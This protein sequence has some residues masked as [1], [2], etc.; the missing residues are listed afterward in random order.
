MQQLVTT[1]THCS[2][3]VASS[4]HAA[5]DGPALVHL[6]NDGSSPAMGC[7]TRHLM[8]G[9]QQWTVARLCEAALHCTA[10]NTEPL[11]TAQHIAVR[12]LVTRSWASLRPWATR[13]Q[14]H[15]ASTSQS[16][17]T[18]HLLPTAVLAHCQAH[19]QPGGSPLIKNKGHDWQTP[20][21]SLAHPHACSH[22][23]V[24]R[25]A[26]HSWYDVALP[27]PS[28]HGGSACRALASIQLQASRQTLPKQSSF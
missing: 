6:F 22:H 18:C 12:Q 8:V 10:A 17:A 27:A 1:G 20:A 19:Q 11:D 3:L 26:A 9:Q 24:A 13:G 5:Q 25:A 14:H 23:C 15:K 4:A 7:Q 2:Q 28:P 16:M 21:D